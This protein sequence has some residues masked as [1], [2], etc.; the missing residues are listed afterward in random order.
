MTSR[1]TMAADLALDPGSP[2]KTFVLEAHTDDPS[3]YLEHLEGVTSVEESEDVFLFQVRT[4]EGNFWVD[5]L[6]PRFGVSIRT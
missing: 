6:D 3:D 1:A 4:D 2:T 5:Q